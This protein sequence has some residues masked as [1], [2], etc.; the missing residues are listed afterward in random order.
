VDGDHSSP[1]IRATLQQTLD[2]L[3]ENGNVVRGP[4]T[5]LKSAE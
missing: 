5:L 2:E 1:A 4:G 3:V